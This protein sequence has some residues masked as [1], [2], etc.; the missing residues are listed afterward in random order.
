MLNNGVRTAVA[1]G[2]SGARLRTG[3]Q[4]LLFSATTLIPP[5]E[6][7]T[8]DAPFAVGFDTRFDQFANDAFH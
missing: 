7:F 3:A 1:F 6:V 2:A 5:M 8:V 4:F